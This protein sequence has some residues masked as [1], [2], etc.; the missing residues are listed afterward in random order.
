MLCRAAFPLSQAALLWLKHSQSLASRFSVLQLV[1][2][3]MKQ[4]ADSG[5]VADSSVCVVSV[6]DAADH[7]DDSASPS[8][9]PAHPPHSL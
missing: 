5:Q 1:W 9:A 7:A 2:C 3:T 4:S 8:A 6:G